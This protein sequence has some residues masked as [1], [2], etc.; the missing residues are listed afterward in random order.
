[1]WIL[2][3]LTPSQA[4]YI[5]IKVTA[6]IRITHLQ[7]MFCQ[8]SSICQTL[9]ALV[10]AQPRTTPGLFQLMKIPSCCP[11]KIL[12]LLVQQDSST[13]ALLSPIHPSFHC[14]HILILHGP[15]D[16]AMGAGLEVFRFPAAIFCLTFPFF[17]FIAVWLLPLWF[18]Y[19][20]LSLPFTGHFHMPTST[21]PAF[22]FICCTDV[23]GRLFDPAA[24]RVDQPF[25]PRP[26]RVV[27]VI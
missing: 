16:P 19:P 4:T 24:T 12:L 7:Q 2:F 14:Q 9:P 25:L 8:S 6:L 26:F 5:L 1:M 13:A 22:R 11:R 20:S 3:A 10:K 21:Q 27:L 17:Q 23:F 18:L 15:V